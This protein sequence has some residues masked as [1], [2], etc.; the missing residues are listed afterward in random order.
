MQI[1]RY[2]SFT[3]M[4]SYDFDTHDSEGQPRNPAPTVFSHVPTESEWREWRK[5]W[6]TQKVI[7]KSGDYFGI[8]HDKDLKNDGKLKPLH[9]HAVVMLKNPMSEDAFRRYFEVSRPENAEHTVS[10]NGALRYLLHITDQAIA[11]FKHIY[12]ESDLFGHAQGF[13]DRDKQSLSV[14][15][16]SKII[17]A[18]NGRSGGKAATPKRVKAIANKL[19][20]MLYR[21]EITL[22]EATQMYEKE[23]GDTGT[24]AFKNVEPALK[25]QWQAYLANKA[26]DFRINGRRLVTDFITGQGGTGKSN[27][28]EAIAY[29][30]DSSHSWHATTGPGKGKTS[31]ITDGYAGEPQAVINELDG[32]AESFRALCALL[33]PY[34]FSKSSSRNKNTDY[35]VDRIHITT[36]TDLANWLIDSIC[37]TKRYWAFGEKLRKLDLKPWE[38]LQLTAQQGWLADDTQTI[39]DYLI[40]ACS[41]SNSDYS[42]VARE[43]RVFEDDAWQLIRRLPYTLEVFTGSDLGIFKGRARLTK[44][45]AIDSFTLSQRVKTVKP[46]DEITEY[47]NHHTF[48]KIPTGDILEANTHFLMLSEIDHLVKRSVAGS[49]DGMKEI[50]ERAQKYNLAWSEFPLFAD[51]ESNGQTSDAI[52]VLSKLDENLRRYNALAGFGIKDITSKEDCRRVGFYIAKAMGI[53]RQN[54]DAK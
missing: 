11:D 3:V 9:M 40:K 28:A 36:S 34:H 44:K 20:G 18:R 42:A 19:G 4:Y 25:K 54:K 16:H 32:D 12:G 27:I 37:Q 53:Y 47:F 7:T 46:L 50:A 48:N 8:F 49:A 29:Y 35:L 31:D 43:L 39:F 17:D 13:L 10:I 23:F 21:G 38:L 15:Y 30:A 41:E 33:D 51:S 26:D 1:K 5:A 45:Q 14:V 6:I 52:V 22:Q 24:V 2:R